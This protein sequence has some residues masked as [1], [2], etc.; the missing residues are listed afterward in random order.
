MT[1]SDAS[2]A[3]AQVFAYLACGKTGA[4]RI[5]AQQLINWLETL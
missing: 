3:L 1:R 4:A 5:A 2:R